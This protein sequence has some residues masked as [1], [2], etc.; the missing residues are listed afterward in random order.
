[1]LATPD[2]PRA[3]RAADAA[4]TT[5]PPVHRIGP[6]A[7]S[8]TIAALDALLGR[9]RTEAVFARAALDAWLQ[10]PP[11]TM[12]DER[13]VARLHRSV[14]EHLP[15]AQAQE[16]MAEAGH[17]TGLY[18]LGNRIPKPAR[19]LLPRLPAG[20]AGRVLLRAITRHAWTFAGSGR[21]SVAPVA[22]ERR[23][24]D[25]RLEDNPL[26]RTERHAQRICVWHQA[27]FQTLFGALLR[28]DIHVGETACLAAGDDSCRFRV[29][30]RASASTRDAGRPARLGMR[31]RP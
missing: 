25:L 2:E 13:A 22:G 18:I 10:D 14:R 29:T 11:E 9:S 21:F 26:A 24:W 12:V 28:G 27:V 8:Q 30:H 4:V 3:Q 16:V 7:V 1:V 6:N 19:L 23:A 31:L 15:F 17:R 5:P 20:L